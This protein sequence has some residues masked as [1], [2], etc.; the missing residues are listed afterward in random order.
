MSSQRIILERSWIFLSIV[1]IY[2]VPLGSIIAPSLLRPKCEG[3]KKRKHDGEG[4]MVLSL[5]RHRVFAPSRY[6]HHV[7]ASSFLR[8]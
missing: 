5:L 3:A 2:G 1:C 6:R 7:F 4:A 8:F